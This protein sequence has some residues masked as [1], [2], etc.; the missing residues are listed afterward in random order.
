MVKGSF[1]ANSPHFV[2]GIIPRV[3]TG[4]IER[5]LRRTKELG[6][7]PRAASLASNLSDS[8]IRDLIRRPQNSPTLET[9][10]KLAEGLQTTPEWLAYGDGEDAPPEAPAEPTQKN[11][12]AAQIGT[13]FVRAA[14]GG[15]VEAGTFRTVDDFEDDPER[16]PYYHPPDRDYPEAKLFYFDVVGDSMNDLKPHPLPDGAKVICLDFESMGGRL[17][18]RDDMVVVIEQTIDGGHHRE[19]SVKQVEIFTDRTEFHPRSTNKRHKP[20]VVPREGEADPLDG[21]MVRI[22][23]VVRQIAI[24]VAI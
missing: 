5:V 9:I 6:L 10:R 3:N 20:I 14:Y 7:S 22:L 15:K 13:R 2:A 19:R 18:P 24:D 1:P 17:P 11:G 16:A 12:R 8:A 21:R 4:L 23:A